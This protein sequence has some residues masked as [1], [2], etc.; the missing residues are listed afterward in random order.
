[1]PLTDVTIRKATPGQRLD[2]GK[3]VEGDPTKPSKLADGGGL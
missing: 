2:K 3:L 1:M